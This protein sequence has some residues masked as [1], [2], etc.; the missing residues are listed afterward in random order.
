MCY[1]HTYEPWSRVDIASASSSNAK[2][3][4]MCVW[5]F[6]FSPFFVFL[7][8]RKFPQCI[9]IDLHRRIVFWCSKIMS[10]EIPFRIG[11]LQITHR[12]RNMNRA[13]PAWGLA[14]FGTIIYHW[15]DPFLR[16]LPPHW[17]GLIS[18]CSDRTRDEFHSVH[19]EREEKEGK[20]QER[21]NIFPWP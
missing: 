21:L 14:V 5:F 20:G 3:K 2:G 16:L 12:F 17:L 18:S 4:E 8:G 9:C 6:H 15:V 19:M 1:A 7:S 13:C 11:C 10:D